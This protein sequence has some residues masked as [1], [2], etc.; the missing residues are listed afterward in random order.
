MYLILIFCAVAVMT[1]GEKEEAPKF[2]TNKARIEMIETINKAEEPT[3]AKIEIELTKFETNKRVKEI[4]TTNKAE[5]PTRVKI[6][7]TNK[8][9]TKHKI[10]TN[11]EMI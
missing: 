6:D 5:E 9:A 7:K 4:E 8:P 2:E 10:E 3:R 11:K 1:V